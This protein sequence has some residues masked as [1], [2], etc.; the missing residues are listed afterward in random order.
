MTMKNRSKI[1]RVLQRVILLGAA[2]GT[3]SSS[4]LAQARKEVPFLENSRV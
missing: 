4:Q 3:L 2:L 1:L